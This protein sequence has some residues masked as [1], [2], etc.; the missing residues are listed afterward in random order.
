MDINLTKENINDANFK[1]S[2][3]YYEKIDSTNTYCKNNYSKL[4]DKSIV[5]AKTQ[6]NGRGK[7]TRVWF[8][9]D[10]GLYFSILLKDKPKNANLLPLLT[11][12]AIYNALKEFNINIKIKWPNDIIFDNKKLGGILVESKISATSKTYIIGIGLNIRSTLPSLDIKDKF[13]SLNQFTKNLA[14]TELILASIINSFSDLLKILDSNP[15]EL[16]SLYRLNCIILNKEVFLNSEKGSKKV[17]V[18]DINN[19][20]SLKVKDLES[21]TIFDIYSGEFSITGLENYI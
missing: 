17:F 21:D 10:G 4:A 1:S 16:L 20:G 9:P 11:S 2:I 3:I 6:T 18:L 5:I 15:S 7:N 8:S 19:D 12:I 14:C 13:T